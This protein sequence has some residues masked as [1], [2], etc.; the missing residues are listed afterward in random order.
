VANPLHRRPDICAFL[1][2]DRLV[3]DGDVDLICWA[4]HDEI[5][6]ATDCKRLAE[7]ATPEDVVTLVRCGVRYDEDEDCL[8]MFV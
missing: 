1:L 7:V 3:P 8:R 6:L 2:L 5:G 4:T